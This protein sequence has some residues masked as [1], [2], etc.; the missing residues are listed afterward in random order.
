MNDGR[1]KRDAMLPE[2]CPA[3][4]IPWGNLADDHS[5]VTDWRAAFGGRDRV[6]CQGTVSAAGRAAL[7][8][9]R[10]VGRGTTA[11]TSAPGRASSGL[12]RPDRF[13]QDQRS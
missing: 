5:A 10:H 11:A 9:Q 8:G 7:R 6:V 4:D 12:G 13:R 2:T 1:V 3:C